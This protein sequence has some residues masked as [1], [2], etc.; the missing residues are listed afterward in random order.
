MA[1]TAVNW[2]PNRYGS[3][4]QVLKFDSAT[5]NYSLEEQNH[6]YTGVN[7][8]FSSLPSNNTT[9]AAT[10]TNTQTQTGTTQSQTTEAFGD[11][12][13]H[14]WQDEGD[15]DNVNVF[16]IPKESS[17]K[18]TFIDDLSDKFKRAATPK[19]Y[20]EYEGDFEQDE[21]TIYPDKK[22]QTTGL[23]QKPKQIWEGFKPLALSAIQAITKRP[24]I[25]GDS[26]SKSH[27][28]VAGLYSKEINLMNNYGSTEPTDGNP[29]GDPRK[30]DAGFN[31]VSGAGNYNMIGTKSRRHNMLK[32]ADIYEKNSNE[33]KQARNKIRA[34][35]KEEKNTGVTNN[36]YN[37]DSSGSKPSAPKDTIKP[38]NG[39]NGSTSGGSGSGTGTS[40][41][42]STG[43][44]QGS[45]GGYNE[46]NYCF[47][48]N[49]S[50]Q[51][52]NGSTKKI[53][54]IQLG[55]NTKGGEVTGV[56]QFK[57]TDEIHDYK[58]VTVAGSHYVKED[59]KFIMVQDSPISVKIDKIPV[60]YSLD[61]TGRRIFIKDIEF[62][63]Y[64]G[65]GIAKGFLH[66]AGLNI[67]GFNK[68]VLRQVEQRLI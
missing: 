18:R 16:N 13:P 21:G 11:V 9:A 2:D 47:D 62:A 7:Y 10:N 37:V 3:V 53:K 23:L 1:R 65:D 32:A 22:K 40:G 64:N 50:I 17:S 35:W 36:N 19:S 55:D 48:P 27:R 28:G 43:Q 57:A 44:S 46:G 33:W 29:T 24:T 34:D 67:N 38:S 52:A 66:N 26:P 6:D 39:G 31:I 58:G 54:E 60:V 5:G 25:S 8:N 4:K 63:D 61:T 42:D 12:K 45:S 56:F 49:T 59:G 41:G 51:M 30:D 14:Y 68:E 15:K 20:Y